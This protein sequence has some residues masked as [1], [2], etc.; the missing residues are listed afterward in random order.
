[1]LVCNSYIYLYVDK[2]NIVTKILPNKVIAYNPNSSNIKA[3][4]YIIFAFCTWRCERC[5]FLLEAILEGLHLLR[6][7][8]K[9]NIF[10]QGRIS[11]Q[12]SWLMQGPVIDPFSAI[13]RG[14][15]TF[16]L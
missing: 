13:K 1:M 7:S 5:S 8:T 2:N 15:D 9:Q 11:S 16:L 12:F 3:V 14:P 6:C 4:L 10:E